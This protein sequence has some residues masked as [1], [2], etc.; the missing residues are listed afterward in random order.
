MFILRSNE[1]L[2]FLMSH[3]GVKLCLFNL[4]A[5]LDSGGEKVRHFNAQCVAVYLH[6]IICF[7]LI[8]NYHIM[9]KPHSHLLCVP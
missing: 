2:H 3:K 6:E 7:V 8:M 9:A 5:G 1:C 4:R